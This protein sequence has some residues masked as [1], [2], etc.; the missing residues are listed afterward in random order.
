M[1]LV[2]LDDLA[3][4]DLIMTVLTRGRG[5]LAK[6]PRVHVTGSALGAVLVRQGRTS[7]QRE[8]SLTGARQTAAQYSL[9]VLVVAKN[10]SMV[11]VSAAGV[12][13]VGGSVAVQ[14]TLVAPCL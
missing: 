2:D 11:P 3:V 6:L 7:S 12:V 9:R 8:F 14:C 10:S 5:A 13:V 4:N 1:A